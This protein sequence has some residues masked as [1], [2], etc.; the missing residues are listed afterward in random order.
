M[1]KKKFL[2]SEL[3][4]WADK[5]YLPEGHLAATLYSSIVSPGIIAI[6]LQL[7]KRT[8]FPLQ[9]DTFCA[10]QP[11]HGFW[12][13]KTLMEL[14]I[15]TAWK[16]WNHVLYINSHPAWFVCTDFKASTHHHRKEFTTEM[17]KRRLW[18]QICTH[19]SNCNAFLQTFNLLLWF[20][21][22]YVCEKLL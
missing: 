6:S 10:Q 17:Y 20:L 18:T 16:W 2:Q 4:Y 9:T 21:V 14:W 11:H 1:K 19:I 3:H 13:P 15:N 8:Y 12:L 22:I 7:G 5:L